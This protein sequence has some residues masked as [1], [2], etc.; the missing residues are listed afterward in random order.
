MHG[1]A[2]STFKVHIQGTHPRDM[3]WAHAA[4]TCMQQAHAAGTLQTGTPRCRHKLWASL[5]GASSKHRLRAHLGGMCSRYVCCQQAHASGA[6]CG[7]I[8][9]FSVQVTRLSA[10]RFENRGANLAH[11]FTKQPQKAASPRACTATNALQY[12]GQF[13]RPSK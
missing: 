13:A 1:N 4:G 10:L 7:H 11:E 12:A 9:V 6:Y 8:L 3:F 2:R 5:A